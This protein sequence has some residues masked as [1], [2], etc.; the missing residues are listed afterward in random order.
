MLD[1]ICERIL[2]Y[3]NDNGLDVDD[4]DYDTLVDR[5]V[6][7]LLR[8]KINIAIDTGIHQKITMHGFKQ[9]P[10]ISLILLVQDLSGEKE[11]RFTVYRLIDSIVKALLLEKLDLPLQDPL[12]PLNFTNVTDQKYSDAG[13]ALYQIDFSCSFN[14]TKDI[15]GEDTG[16]LLEIINKYYLEDGTLADT[17]ILDLSEIFGGNAFTADFSEDIFGGF[18]GTEEFESEIYGGV[19]ESIC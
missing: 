14:Y 2:E 7:A 1:I 5:E 9:R 3:L 13:Y 4:I 15:A 18:A 17:E 8:P 11:R 19:A 10:T 6:G 12:I 16:E